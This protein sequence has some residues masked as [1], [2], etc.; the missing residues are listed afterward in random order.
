MVALII[1]KEGGYMKKAR[2]VGL[3]LAAEMMYSL[4]SEYIKAGFTQK[5]ALEL[6]KIHVSATQCS[7]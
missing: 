5:Q 6:M 1:T 7:K 4:Y 2:D 3:V